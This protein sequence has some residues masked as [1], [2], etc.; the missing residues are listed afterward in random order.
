MNK[1][2]PNF[3]KK[4]IQQQQD[5]NWSTALHKLKDRQLRLHMATDIIIIII[6]WGQPM[7]PDRASLMGNI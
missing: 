2:K 3:S 6:G 4:K 5:I 7:V 1:T